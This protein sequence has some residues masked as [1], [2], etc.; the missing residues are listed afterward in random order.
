MKL[1]KLDPIGRT[2]I[3][4]TKKGKTRVFIEADGKR[5]NNDCVDD[6][7]ADLVCKVWILV[8]QRVRVRSVECFR[9]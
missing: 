4:S 7:L 8:K 1:H 3:A 9:S 6:V 5:R 2:L